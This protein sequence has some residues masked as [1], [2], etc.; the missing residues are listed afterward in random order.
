[1]KIE[2]KETNIKPFRDL[3]IGETFKH[4]NVKEVY[5]KTE[6]ISFSNDY[7]EETTYN[8]VGLSDGYLYFKYD[9]SEVEPVK[10]KVVVEK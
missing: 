4:G 8:C 3:L 7:E 1:M 10:S 9:D 6:R 2:Y 5:M